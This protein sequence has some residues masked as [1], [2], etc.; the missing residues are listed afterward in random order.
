MLANPSVEVTEE[1]LREE[2]SFVLSDLRNMG[3][4]AAA[5]FVVLVLLAQFL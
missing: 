4:L 3:I 1:Q 2:Y 5:L